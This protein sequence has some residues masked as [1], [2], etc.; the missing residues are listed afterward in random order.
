MDCL[1]TKKIHLA[2]LPGEDVG[3]GVRRF[4]ED[5][6]ENRFC[7]DFAITE[8]SLVVELLQKGKQPFCSLFLKA[9]VN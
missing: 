7:S 4:M 2:E 9:H 5:R 6:G 1:S 3:A 8:K